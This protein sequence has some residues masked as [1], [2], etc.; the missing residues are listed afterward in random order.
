M[1]EQKALEKIA[2]T[3]VKESFEAAKDFLAAIGGDAIS[4][5][6]GI[7]ADTV[8]YWRFKNSVNLALKARDFLRS[9]GIDPRKVMPSTLLPL[10]E[11]ASIQEDPFLQE[12]WARLLASAASEPDAVRVA[13]VQ[14]LSGLS[15]TDVQLLNGLVAEREFEWYERSGTTVAIDYHFHKMKREMS[16]EESIAIENFLRLGI[17]R[18]DEPE[19]ELTGEKLAEMLVNIQRG[20]HVWPLRLGEERSG[21]SYSITALGIHFIVACAGPGAITFKPQPTETPRQPRNSKPT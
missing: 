4:A 20:G 6:G 2:E 3:A 19:I 15:A 11:A 18:R 17:L 7:F 14:M 1:D 8:K 21:P 5:G 9:K 10:L 16:G 13:F 12:T